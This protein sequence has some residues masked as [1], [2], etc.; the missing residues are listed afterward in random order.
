M[1]M[2]TLRTL[3]AF[4]TSGKS[5]LTARRESTLALPS[6]GSFFKAFPNS[7]SAQI[8]DTS[9]VNESRECSKR[10]SSSPTLKCCA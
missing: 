10:E 8:P 1:I 6:R 3:S 4:K 2:H 5:A 7:P 9:D